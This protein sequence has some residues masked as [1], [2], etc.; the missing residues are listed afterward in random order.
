MYRWKLT[1]QPLFIHSQDY[2]CELLTLLPGDNV[3]KTYL[4]AEV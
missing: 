2:L 4:K 1:Q 3:E